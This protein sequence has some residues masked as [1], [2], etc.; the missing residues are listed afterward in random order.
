[1]K[2]YSRSPDEVVKRFDD[3][4]FGVNKKRRSGRMIVLLNIA[5]LG[6]GVYFFKQ[7]QGMKPV[8]EPVKFEWGGWAFDASCIA[9]ECRASADPGKDARPLGVMHWQMNSNG[10]ETLFQES[11]EARGTGRQEFV[12]QPP[13]RPGANAVVFLR[14]V[15]PDGRED[16]KLRV[17]Q[18][19]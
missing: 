9:G 3:R 7:F 17:W 10:G 1:M 16:F 18:G 5:L 12:F 14:M 4:A 6:A 19:K 15:R 11:Q 8:T 13:F 2:Y